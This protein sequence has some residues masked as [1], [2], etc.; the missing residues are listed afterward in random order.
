MYK[1]GK[2][3]VIEL[4]VK[5]KNFLNTHYSK[6]RIPV[7]I[8]DAAI[9]HGYSVGYDYMQDEKTVGIF[10]PKRKIITVKLDAKNSTQKFA[11]AHF[12][13]HVQFQ[14]KSHK[15][16]DKDYI[17]NIEL[18]DD[19]KEIEMNYFALALLIPESQLNEFI[20]K[21]SNDLDDIRKYFKVS[22]KLL[23]YRIKLLSLEKSIKL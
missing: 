20:D 18:E 9:D 16:I 13:S 8:S 5:A 10:D 2:D 3:K 1:L 15:K 4:E 6:V 11:I 7:K 23:Y 22:Y 19:I 17:K 14:N 12:L 21:K